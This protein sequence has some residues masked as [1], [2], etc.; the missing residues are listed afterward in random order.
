[1]A[2]LVHAGKVRYLGL[3]EASAATVRRACQV[4]PI[5]AL[6]SEYS[7][8]TRDPEDEVLAACRKLGVGF[9]PFSPLG[10]GFLTGQIRRFEDLAPDDFR[11]TSPRFQGENFQKNLEL[12]RRVTAL[13]HEKGCTAAQLALAWVLARGPDI[14]PIPGTKRRRYLEENL[15]ALHVTLTPDDLH[16][17]D[18]IA[19]RGVAAGARYPEA[20][21]K[22]VNR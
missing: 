17:I 14:V 11:R 22:M 12:V 2:D 4:H 13:A 1:M 20:S 10:R 3:S 8:W 5:T 21:M 18:E 15:G 6:Q 9:V 16:R 19:P 7:L